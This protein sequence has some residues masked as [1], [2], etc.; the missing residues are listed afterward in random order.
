MSR[1]VGTEET[2]GS[3][4]YE[5]ERETITIAKMMPTAVRTFAIAERVV[6]PRWSDH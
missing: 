4:H 6:M 5:R 3:R 1:S 2:S